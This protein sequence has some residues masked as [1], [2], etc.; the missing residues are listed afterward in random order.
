MG[1]ILFDEQPIVIDRTLAKKIG[2]NEA[3]ILQQIHYWI[4]NNKKANRNFINGMYWTYNSMKEWHE[5]EF[6][7]WSFDT[8]KR[9]FAKLVKNGLL[10]KD[11]FNKDKRD[12]TAWY[13]INYVKLNEIMKTETIEKSTPICKSA[14]CTNA[15]DDNTINAKVQNAPMGECKMHQPLP[16]ITTKTSTEISIC[17]SSNSNLQS[18][19]KLNLKNEFEENICKL[20]KYTNVDFMNYEKVYDKNF[21]LG[22]IEYC[23]AIGIKSFAGFKKVIDSYISKD[24]LTREKMFED[25]EKF[26]SSKKYKN[27]SKKSNKTDSFNDRKQRDYN[28]MGGLDAIEKKLLKW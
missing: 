18:H 6:S 11:N 2:L 9:T 28:D 25:I 27:I 12:R 13:T 21:I 19:K 4:S 3:I 1:K 26:R 24:I 23:A 20:R 8:V 14:K 16:E 7:F 10:L 15:K 22:V 17:S 5:S